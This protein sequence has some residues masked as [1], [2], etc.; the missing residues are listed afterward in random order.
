[1]EVYEDLK[2]TPARNP[3]DRGIRSLSSDEEG[4]VCWFGNYLERVFPAFLL[5]PRGA[6]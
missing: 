1:M 2:G 5:R 6:I 3:F 4:R